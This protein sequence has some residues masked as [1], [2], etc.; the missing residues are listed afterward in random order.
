MAMARNRVAGAGPTRLLP[1][2]I[3]LMSFIFMCCAGLLTTL[4][5]Q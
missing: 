4:M 5:Q 1:L 2:I 3:V